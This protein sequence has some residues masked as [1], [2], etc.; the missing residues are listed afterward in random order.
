MS[1]FFFRFLLIL[2]GLHILA[3]FCL[4]QAVQEKKAR[5][6]TTE[7]DADQVDSKSEEE[8]TK[9]TRIRSD[10]A[11]NPVAFE[12]SIVTYEGKNDKGEPITVDLVGAIHIGSAGYYEALNK[13]FEQYE[14]LLYELV[15]PEGTVIKKGEK[16]DSAMNVVSGFQRTMK[17]FL[18]LDFQL[19]HI[20]YT[21]KNFVHADMSPEEFSQSMKANDE[22]PMRLFFR[23]MGH[24]MASQGK[25]GSISDADL[26]SALFSE[27]R[28]LK[29]R[30]I[31]AQQLQS[32]DDMLSVFEGKDG[33][34]I[35][36]HR[37]K[38]ALEVLQKELQSG[39]K[40]LGIFYGAGH[41]PEMEASLLEDFDLKKTKERW[42]TAWSLIDK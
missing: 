17:D 9:F 5:G 38:K 25:K 24:S 2:I 26:L 4:A 37:N 36:T 12:T 7:K 27:D 32:G 42:L 10:A 20:D 29:L 28:N 11:G 30:K 39:K 33:S 21:K 6:A 16:R 23:I 14:S 40:K 3:S 13:E 1:Q 41:F 22:S 34:T 19:D 35:I 18:G 8:A 31:L 15:A